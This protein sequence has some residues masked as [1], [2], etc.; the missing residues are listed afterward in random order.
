MKRMLTIYYDEDAME[1]AKVDISPV[2][3]S[4]TY[5]DKADVLQDCL[6]AV[7]ELYDRAAGEHLD[8]MIRLH[9]SQQ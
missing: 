3:D 6:E 4:E 9:E 1:L 5:L 2:F 7:G 8:D